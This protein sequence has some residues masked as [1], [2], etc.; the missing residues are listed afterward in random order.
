V[1][2]GAG[3]RRLRV[4]SKPGRSRRNG[5]DEADGTVGTKQ[6]WW[7][8]GPSRWTDLAVSVERFDGAGPKLPAQTVR[9]WPQ[10]SGFRG[11]GSWA[12]RLRFLS[13]GCWKVTGR[14]RDV[15][16]AFVVDVDIR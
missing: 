8:A 4:R 15:S 14:V 12:A 16:L 1:G 10:N 13:E 5:R 7:A 11:S 3:Q 9:G 2:G 6:L